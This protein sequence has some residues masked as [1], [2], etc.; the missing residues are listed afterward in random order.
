MD[1]T[2]N[3]AAQESAGFFDAISAWFAKLGSDFHLNFIADNRWKLLVTGLKNTLIMTAGALV[4]G[5]LIGVLV[6]VVRSVWDTNSSKMRPGLGKSVFGLCDKL[7]RLYTTV[8]RGTPMMV[9]LLI[10]VF[11]VFPWVKDTTFNLGGWK[12]LIDA[13][14]LVAVIAF[15]L[16]SG[17]YVSEIFR[18]GI[19][20]IDKGQMEAGRSVGL[21]YVQTMWYIIAPQV[22]KNVLPT[23]CSEFIMLLKETSIAAYAGVVDLTMAGNRIRG[24]TFTDFMPLI[25][26]A[27]I[28]L[29]IVTILTKLVGML[30]RRLRE[31]DAR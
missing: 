22:V 30:E 17:A 12:I 3:V 13:E 27:L 24:Q 23:L 20:S 14:M 21:D 5:I 28:Y 10:M 19:M 7:C 25:A 15:G 31:S 1:V 11:V 26:V 29:L 4:I 6:A 2:V 18:G 8:V 9:Q 16:N